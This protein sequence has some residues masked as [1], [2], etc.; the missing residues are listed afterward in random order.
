VCRL[1][2]AQNYLDELSANGNSR[3]KSFSGDM[4]CEVNAFEVKRIVSVLH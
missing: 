2:C 1:Y 4:F 3:K